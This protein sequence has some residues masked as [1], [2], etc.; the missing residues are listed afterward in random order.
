MAH[1]SRHLVVLAVTLLILNTLRLPSLARTRAR[2][3]EQVGG[4]PLPPVLP[5]YKRIVGVWDEFTVT[6]ESR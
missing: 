1:A 5:I 3:L 2:R 4:P 6:A